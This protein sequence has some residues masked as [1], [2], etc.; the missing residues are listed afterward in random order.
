MYLFLQLRIR[1]YSILL[2]T[3]RKFKS[4]KNII[5]NASWAY[6]QIL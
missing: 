4:K 5:K 3:T 1:I 2:V 6:I